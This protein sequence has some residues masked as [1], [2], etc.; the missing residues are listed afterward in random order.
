VQVR[1]DSKSGV[2]IY[3]Q[4]KNQIRYQIAAGKL[5][6]GEQ[7]P[8]VRQLAVDLTINPNTVARVYLE[9]ERE[10]LLTTQQGRG[11]FVS[12]TGPAEELDEERRGRLQERMCQAIMEGLGM[13]FTL[14]ELSQE[15]ERILKD[16]SDTCPS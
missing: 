5:L 1:I 10:G 12:E 14:E 8:T 4:L 13:G 7:L 11:T 16:W 2:P 6:R 3:V 9:L 15:L